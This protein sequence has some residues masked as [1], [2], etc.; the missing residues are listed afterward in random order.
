MEALEEMEEELKNA[1]NISSNSTPASRDPNSSH[2]SPADPATPDQE[3][4]TYTAMQGLVN[5]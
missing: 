3:S 1:F 4:S 2:A 5:Y